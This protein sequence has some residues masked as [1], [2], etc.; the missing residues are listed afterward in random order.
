MPVIS[1]RVS[2]EEKDFLEKV[3]NFNGDNIS[4]FMRSNSLQSAESLVDF[5]TYKKLM[6]EHE[7]L[8]KAFLHE[9]C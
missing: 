6:K 3:A 8:I 1:I 4:E 2:N 7:K 9:K 5:E